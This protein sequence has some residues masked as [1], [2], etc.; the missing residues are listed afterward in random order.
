[1]R[2]SIKEVASRPETIASVPEISLPMEELI[3]QGARQVIEQVV[4]AEL[5]VFMSS[6]AHATTTGGRRVVVRNGYQPE[7]DVL[8]LR[9]SLGCRRCQLRWFPSMPRRTRCRR[10]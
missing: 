6:Y 9:P 8:T 4:A 7:R 5:Q 1:M 3:R 2:K 10:W